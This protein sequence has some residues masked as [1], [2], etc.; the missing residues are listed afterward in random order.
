MIKTL[1]PK[2]DDITRDWVL[3]DAKG[4]VLGR[5]ATKIAIVLMGKTK[6]NFV[7]HFDMGD[8]V[9][10][11]NAADIVVTGNKDTQKVYHHH[12]GYPGG[13]KVT[14]Y[15]FVLASKPEEIIKSAV[16]GMIPQNRLH[17]RIMSHLHI[18]PSAEHPYGKQFKN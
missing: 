13:M 1:S 16:A 6:S 18:Y 10:V 4:Q 9:V 17:D 3:F 8:H 2:A 5:L 12:S 11:V 14:S 7:R 15:K